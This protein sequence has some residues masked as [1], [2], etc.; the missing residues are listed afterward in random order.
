MR[1]LVVPAVS[2]LALVGCHH[3]NVAILELALSSSSGGQ[4]GFP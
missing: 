1:T 4:S 3:V 2:C